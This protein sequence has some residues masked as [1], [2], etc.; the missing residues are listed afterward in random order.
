MK[1]ATE[2]SNVISVSGSTGLR[3]ERSIGTILI[4]AG[5]LTFEST[6]KIAQLQR[7]HGLRFGD[8]ALQLG[9]L[10]AADIE[11]ALA[12]QFDYP[13]LMRGDSKV[14]EHVVA[15]YAPFSRQTA[16]ISALRSQ[17]MLRWFDNA[18]EG[19]AL[20]IV[21]PDR[22]EGRSFIA[23]NLAV[24]FSQLGKKTLLIDADMRNA[25]QHIVFGIDNHRGLSTILAG[26]AVTDAVIQRI[27]GLLGLSVVSAGVQPPNPLELLARSQFPQL[28]ADLS[29]DF[30]VIIL[31]S[32]A[33][34]ENTDAQCIAARAGAALIVAR[35]GATRMSHVHDAAETV[36]D[37]GAVVVGTVLNDF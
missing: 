26:R 22:R 28:L 21:S 4:H 12:R 1:A 5:R 8:A 2:R 10:T 30:E 31:D 25:N 32:P 36:S 37:A 3:E 17:L 11:L 20:A 24:A 33:A 23:A 7:E 34:A 18:A 19:K 14:S 9:L 6:E 16:T 35:K 13:Y 29:L 15:A 27:P